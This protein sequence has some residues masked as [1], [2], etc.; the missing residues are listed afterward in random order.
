MFNR[1]QYASAPRAFHFH[2][3]Y[4]PE[5]PRKYDGFLVRGPTK[6]ILFEM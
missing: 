6:N 3:V 1:V 2:K 5:N 4:L